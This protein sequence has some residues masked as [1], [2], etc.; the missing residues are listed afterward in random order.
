MRDP[1]ARIRRRFTAADAG[2][3]QP[4]LAAPSRIPGNTHRLC[5][6]DRT[7]RVG[8]AAHAWRAPPAARL[9]RSRNALAGGGG[10][11]RLPGSI[12]YQRIAFSKNIRRR[13]PSENRPVIS[14]KP[15]MMAP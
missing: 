3:L 5:L 10:S 4:P 15:R 9:Y 12:R 2:P 8:A 1:S 7:I 14:W 13:S 11:V 6:A